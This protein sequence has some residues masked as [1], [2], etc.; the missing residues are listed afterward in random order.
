MSA[1]TAAA[2]LIAATVALQEALG[3]L[4]Q[5]ALCSADAVA[6]SEAAALVARMRELAAHH[7]V[8]LWTA[9]AR[10]YQ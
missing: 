9:N 3:E 5:R 1:S 7:D 4:A 10:N 2:A 8:R 6:V